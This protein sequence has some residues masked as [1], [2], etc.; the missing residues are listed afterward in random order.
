[1]CST[2]V[3]TTQC[4]W[5]AALCFFTGC[6]QSETTEKETPLLKIGSSVLFPS[7]LARH[8]RQSV[9]SDSAT[10]AA[11]FLEDWR[12]TISLYEQALQDG[13]QH[14]EE[15]QRIVEKS[16]Q[17]IIAERFVERKLREALKRGQFRVDSAEVKTYYEQMSS[18]LVFREAMFKLLRI[19]TSNA[20][21]ALR[22]RQALVA[23]ISMDSLFKLI[24]LRAPE[25]V[26]LNQVA[27]ESAMQL[28]TLP[29]LHLES[30]NLY[31]VLERMKPNDVS[32]VMKLSDSL[33][34]VMRLEE[35]VAQKQP[36][37]FAQAFPE[38]LERLRMMKQKRF[39]DSLASRLKNSL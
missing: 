3:S 2:A 25:T 9:S 21:T 1:M 10:Q 14:D 28:K 33:F 8:I 31:A 20:D 16:R 27:F 15:T 13:E 5:L 26:A 39:V 36:K 4:F 7:E 24:M 11:L 23:R 12:K 34:V 32:P 17:R 37:T 38:I 22:F 35:S 19:Y 18:K 30:E 6:A 29:Q